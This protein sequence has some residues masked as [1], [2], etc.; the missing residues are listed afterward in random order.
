MSRRDSP[1][2]KGRTFPSL[3]TPHCRNQ[4]WGVHGIIYHYAPFFLRNKMETLS[5]LNSVISSHV[6]SPS[7]HL[8]GKKHLTK[9]GNAW[10]SPQEHSRIPITRP[11]RC[12]L[13]IL[14]VF[15]Q[16][17]TGP[18]FLKDSSKR[19]SPVPKE[20]RAPQLLGKLNWSIPAVFRKLGWQWPFWANPYSTVEIQGTQF[21]S[22]DFQICIEP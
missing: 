4:E 5:R 19:S 22:Q 6:T 11:S 7:V 13:F 16:G 18:G 21:I 20:S 2:V 1:Q 14:T 9:V 8:E 17:N 3:C 10:W 12:W 15:L